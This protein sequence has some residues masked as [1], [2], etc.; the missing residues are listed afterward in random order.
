MIPARILL[1]VK[2]SAVNNY[3]RR[4]GANR[5]GARHQH[6][7][8]STIDIYVTFIV[9]SRGKMS[10]FKIYLHFKK[11]H[12]GNEQKECKIWGVLQLI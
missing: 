9:Y 2:G 7:L 11:K 10:Y 3:T 6:V 5:D 8:Q 12:K 4:T 1:S